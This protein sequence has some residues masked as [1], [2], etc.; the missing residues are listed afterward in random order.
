MR[1]SSPIRCR[2]PS[3]MHDLREMVAST[4]KTLGELPAAISADEAVAHLNGLLHQYESQVQLRVRENY[5]QTAFLQKIRDK[6]MVPFVANVENS[7]PV[8][9]ESEGLEGDRLKIEATE[10]KSYAGRAE[11]V[12][13][14]GKAFRWRPDETL[15]GQCQEVVCDLED[16]R[17]LKHSVTTFEL[18]GNI[19]FVVKTKLIERSLGHVGF[20]K[21][22]CALSCKA[23]LA[24]AMDSLARQVFESYSHGRLLSAVRQSIRAL[25]QDCYEEAQSYLDQYLRTELEVILTNNPEEYKDGCTH[26]LNEMAEKRQAANG[27][28]IAS[29]ASEAAQAALE[30]LRQAGLH[31]VQSD[32]LKKLLP[33]DKYHEE[34][35]LASEVSAYHG[36]AVKRIIDVVPSGILL[37]LIR[38]FGSRVRVRLD[39]DLKIFDE[40]ARE[41]AIAWLAEDSELIDKRADLMGRLQRLQ[42]GLAAVEAFGDPTQRVG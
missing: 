16:I 17:K 20:L 18:P 14:S 23:S 41:R 40:G 31:D 12:S 38:A 7:P 28:E 29:I 24:A 6:Y 1:T 37:H 5:E 32:D 8:F 10:G 36:M 21:D 33:R 39:A 34:M 11:L 3:L 22:Q 2:L 35:E 30:N 42:V 26:F 13:D 19:P 15:A 4:T 27:I 25:E 9:V